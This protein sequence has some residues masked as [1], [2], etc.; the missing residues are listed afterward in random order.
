[1]LGS[2]I[3]VLIFKE[4]LSQKNYLGI[5]LALLAIILLTYAQLK[6]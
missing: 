5:C 4:K 2:L 1:V 3:G 6:A